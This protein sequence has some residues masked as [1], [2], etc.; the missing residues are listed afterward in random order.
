[1]NRMRRSCRVSVSLTEREK[2][3]LETIAE[4][5]DL[6]LSRI[7]QEAIREFA[8]NHVNKRV[9][10]LTASGQSASA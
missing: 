3:D 8:K 1:M 2:Q 10:L 9:D 4:R 5:S 6:S 7:I